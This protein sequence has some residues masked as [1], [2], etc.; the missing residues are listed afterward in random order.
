MEKE[1]FV[2][3]SYLSNYGGI[4]TLMLR[5][6]KWLAEN[7]YPSMIVT[8]RERKTDPDL[9]RELERESVIKK[10]AFRGYKEFSAK[11]D[12][13]IGEEEAPKLMVFSYP[14]YLIAD[15]IRRQTEKSQII[16]YDPHQYGLILEF[17]FHNRFLKKAAHIWGK[18][19]ARRMDRQHEIAYM[20]G[21]CMERTARTY[22]CASRPDLVVPLA[23]QIHAFDRKQAEARYERKAFHILT[24]ARME[25][26]FKGYVIGLIG[27]FE[28]LCRQYPGLHLDLVGDGS[29]HRRLANRIRHLAPDI[30]KRVH[31]HGTVPYRDLDAYFEKAKLY[32]GMGTTVLDAANHGIISLPVGSYT[33]HCKGYGF[34]QDD[35]MNLG[36]IGGKTP[37]EELIRQ[38]LG[39]SKEEYCDCVKKQF[40][41]MAPLYEIDGVM[42]RLLTWNNR[43]HASIFCGWERMAIRLGRWAYR[44]RK[45]VKA[46]SPRRCLES[47]KR[48]PRLFRLVHRAG[49]TALRIPVLITGKMR[50][51][52]WLCDSNTAALRAYQNSHLGERCVLVANGPSLLPED[53]DKIKHEWTFGC[54]KIYHIFPRTSWRP[55]FYCLLDERYVERSQDEIFSN[56]QAPIFTNDVIYRAI[57]AENKKGRKILYSKQIRY[58]TFKAWPNLLEYT[59]ATNQ[60][61]VLSFVMALAIYMGFQEIYVLGADNTATAAGNHFA[62]HAEDKGLEEIQKARLKENGWNETH[63]RD[64]MELEMEAFARYAKN[65]GISI[66][67]V[68]R[69]GRLEAFERKNFD[70]VFP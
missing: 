59:Y 2:L 61:T 63:W 41:A 25:F 8:D 46:C 60:G 21:L 43:G 58:E 32:I 70:E 51:Y 30:Q 28:Q 68:T 47:L 29:N 33:Y 9:F 23:M 6:V 48:H 31:W 65:H 37:M 42:H 24:V 10:I 40:A 27:I 52:G 44:K 13:G 5:M 55:D 35:A 64:Q 18:R 62:G 22:G 69:G 39:F 1:R 49:I 56:I 14:G 38:V 34:L 12:L 17:S 16:F 20:D 3:I 19:L 53:L 26:P 4:E 54:N 36:G 15:E 11:Q 66:S 67:N 45:A 7:G 57:R 50:A